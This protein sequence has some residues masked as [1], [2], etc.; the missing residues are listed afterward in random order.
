MIFEKIFRNFKSLLDKYRIN[1]VPT[2]DTNWQSESDA[3]R[4]SSEHSFHA[5]N[6]LAG[7]IQTQ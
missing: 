5:E 6:M 3:R 1:V 7:K 4:S 2:V